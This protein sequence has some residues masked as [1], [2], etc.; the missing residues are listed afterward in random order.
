MSNEASR[1]ARITYLSFGKIKKPAVGRQA[2]GLQLAHLIPHIERRC[3][4]QIG[5]AIA[6]HHGTFKSEDVLLQLAVLAQ[7]TPGRRVQFF[8]FF[9]DHADFGCKTIKMRRDF[10]QRA[11]KRLP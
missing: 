9:L 2:L 10:E 1:R 8:K 6:L 11:S 3:T 4:L 5:Q 7:E